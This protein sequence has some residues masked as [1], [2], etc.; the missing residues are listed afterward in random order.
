MANALTG[1]FEAVLQVSGATVNRLLASMHQ[2]AGAN[3][4]T[5]SFPHSMRMRIGDPEPVD[6]IKGS[7]SAQISVPHVDLIHGVTD[8]FWLEVSIRARY[9]PDAGTVPLPEFIHG[10]VRAQ[11]R[12]DMIDR[13]C[14]GWEKIASDF[15]WVR[16]VED[17]VSFTGTAVDDT[18]LISATQASIDP[19]TADAR[20]TRVARHL[21]KT[22]FQATPH[23]VS[24]RFR[25]GTMRSL[26]T[27]AKSSLV[28]IPIGI[29]GDPT[30][31]KIESINQ[32]ILG[33]RDV[34]IG[35]NRDVIMSRIQ[36][37]LDEVRQAF[38]M[39]FRSRTRGG[40][41]LGFADVKVAQVNIDWTITL[42]SATAQWLGGIPPFMGV[43]LAG[44]LVTIALHG[45][46]R[47]QKA[48]FNF[49]FDVS[50]TMLITF[51]PA[52][53]DF[54]AAPFGDA[55][56]NVPGLLGPLIEM[57]ARSEIQAQVSTAMKSAAAGLAGQVS[58]SSRKTELAKQLQTMD[59]QAG[60]SFSSAVFSA[61][62]VVVRGDITVS[63]RRAP[64][65][66]FGFASQKSGYSAFESWIPGGTIDSFNW[67]WKWFNN[68]GKPG[69]HTGVDRYV[70]RRPAA[71]GQGKFGVMLGLKDPLPGLD[72]MGQV[73]LVVSGTHTHPVT[74]E[75]VPV[76]VRRRCKRFGFDLS[77]G[78]PDRL[79]L[80][81]WTPG[82]R[83]PIGPV[84]EVAV[85]DVSSRTSKGHGA[86][87]LVVRAGKG[88][89]R[90]VAASLRD[91][92][93][94]CRRRDAG[95]VV[96]LLFDDGRLTD[97]GEQMLE[98]LRALAQELEAPL[99][100]NEDVEGSWSSALRI[101]ESDSLEWR[102][103]TP[104]GGVSWAHSGNLPSRELA[105]ALDDYLI[106]SSAPAA[107]HYGG[108]AYT[109][110]RVRPYAFESDVIGSLTRMEDG[111]PPP[112]FER[113]GLETAVKFVRRNAYSSDVALRAT[114]D[115]SARG[116]P[117]AFRVI[118][119]DGATREDEQRMREIAPDAMIVADGDG[120]I[121]ERFGIRSW[122]F[123]LRISETG[124]ISE[125]EETQHE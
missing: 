53:E 54:E 96:F 114:T 2:N 111:C 82:P 74:G 24:G 50:Q 122:P 39:I 14:F 102:L 84:S 100:V 61:D 15:L 99:V 21:L 95:L 117:E 16:V 62:G 28:A 43:S 104:N 71:K 52:T 4:E 91:G 120:A 79:F 5:P 121:A 106:R 73:C 13:R 18:A 125:S 124:M 69:F 76:T 56:V 70:L 115:E 48:I 46:A 37:Q 17:T 87:T 22:T 118:V 60:V 80:R 42:T 10:T 78:T 12:I 113:L 77:L 35:I 20:I 1:D 30:G 64:D 65:V 49:D 44:G 40:I 7:A 75:S 41:N 63:P 55:T 29:S 27:G 32:N 66:S 119:L 123:D 38:R 59:S 51:N 58:I 25:R 26:N 31:G 68:A 93:A 88:W 19:S 81:E 97:P 33:G 45:Q 57:A 86:N 108:K 3:A 107:R 92:L 110:A 116:E 83:D 109:G 98:E 112:P 11:Y 89:N 101:T 6:G 85:H 72:G 67:Q 36:A 103:V 34:A 9:T 94:D 23:K 105:G 8:R 47:T 90:E